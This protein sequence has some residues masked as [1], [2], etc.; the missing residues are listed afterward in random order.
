MNNE[1]IV[2]NINFGRMLSKFKDKTGYEASCNEIRIND[3]VDYYSDEV[4]LL[5]LAE[6]IMT[7]WEYKLRTAYPQYKFC[8]ILS[9]NDGYATM[10]FHIIRENENPWLKADL[11]GYK[12]EA[13]MVK[14][15]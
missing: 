15:F 13:I 12:N 2:E 10:R 1:I 5:Q 4:A 9:F 6:I 14:E 3:Y 8:M 11:N 7:A